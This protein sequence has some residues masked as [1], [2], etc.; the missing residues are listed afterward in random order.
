MMVLSMIMNKVKKKKRCFILS[1]FKCYEKERTRTK[2]E[3]SRRT[4]SLSYFFN[5]SG[6]EFKVCKSFYLGTL[7]ISLKTVYNARK[8]KDL[9]TLMPQTSEWGKH[10]KNKVS[11]DRVQQVMDHI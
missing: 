10:P 3:N 8:K 6:A 11:D 7:G 9:V 2:T 1:T 4:N 5:L